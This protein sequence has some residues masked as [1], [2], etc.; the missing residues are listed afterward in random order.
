MYK[1]RWQ[2]SV[3]TV[4]AILCSF[5]SHSCANMPNRRI[6][7]MTWLEVEAVKK[8]SSVVIIPLG[9]AAKEHGPHLPM[10]NDYIM[11]NYL[12]DRILAGIKEALALP[13]INYSYYP[14]FLEYTGSTSIDLKVAADMVVDICHSLSKQGFK[15]FYVLNTGFSTM[16]ALEI[17]KEQLSAEHISM[18]YLQPPEFFDSPAIK[19]LEQ[20]KIGSHADEIETSMMLYI[21]PEIVRME[22]A[23]KDEHPRLGPGGLT[24]NPNT[25]TG[26]YSASGAWGDPTLATKQKGKVITEAYV[27]FILDDIHSFIEAEN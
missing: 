22:K 9:A 1:L 3:L 17:A 20:Q 26:I 5:V 19:K 13:V 11:A 18:D 14:A 23:V 24:R 15:K 16:K 25:K 2:L 12:T 10:N 7:N 27:N 21:A 4:F 8:T 6:E